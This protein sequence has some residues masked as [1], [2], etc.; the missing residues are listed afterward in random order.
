MGPIDEMGELFESLLALQHPGERVVQSLIAEVAL[1]P[2]TY[3]RKT[4]A[5]WK[6]LLDDIG[7]P[8]PG[9]DTIVDL[10]ERIPLRCHVVV[11]EAKAR[12]YLSRRAK[13]READDETA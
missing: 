12:A 8:G 6:T 9:G 3:C 10:L 4:K 1:D 2:F 13:Q 11:S 7:R 5:E